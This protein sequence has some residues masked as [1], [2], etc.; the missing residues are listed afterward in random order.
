M[1]EHK[2]ACAQSLKEKLE[3]SQ[4]LSEFR[5][6]RWESAERRLAVAW[7]Q[8]LEAAR[9]RLGHHL[10]RCKDACLQ[11]WFYEELAGMMKGALGNYDPIRSQLEKKAAQLVR[12]Y[13]LTGNDYEEGV[14]DMLRSA[15]SIFGE[16]E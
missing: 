1:E 10:P 15:Q 4:K 13:G 3:E 6:E 12:K 7:D 5:K 8:A 9:M 16:K 2:C 11:C 14:K